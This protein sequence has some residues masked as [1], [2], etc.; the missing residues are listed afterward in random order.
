M[1]EANE[2]QSPFISW[3]GSSRRGRKARRKGSIAICSYYGR[4]T[5]TEFNVV[6]ERRTLVGSA[7]SRKAA[8]EH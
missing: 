7:G 2:P 5:A 6:R 8:L 4:K 3:E 1:L